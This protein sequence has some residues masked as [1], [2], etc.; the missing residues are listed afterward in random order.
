MDFKKSESGFDTNK[1]NP[2]LS[3]SIHFCLLGGHHTSDYSWWRADI[4]GHEAWWTGHARPLRITLPSK[5]D[6]IS[7]LRNKNRYSGPVR[8][9]QLNSVNFLMI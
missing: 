6:A 3:I 2:F 1:M 8:I 7:I 5:E 4:E 9:K